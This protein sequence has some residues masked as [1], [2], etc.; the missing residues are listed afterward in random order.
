[1]SKHLI[2]NITTI[3][4]TEGNIDTY[5]SPILGNIKKDNETNLDDIKLNIL[6]VG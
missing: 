2:S 1:M 4:N 3:E 6:K 5:I